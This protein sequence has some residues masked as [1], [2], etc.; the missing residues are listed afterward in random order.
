[1]ADLH[2]IKALN[3]FDIQD[4]EGLQLTQADVATL[5]NIGNEVF[6]LG[7]DAQG[8]ALGVAAST[9]G[10][11]SLFRM[12]VLQ[13]VGIGLVVGGVVTWGALRLLGKK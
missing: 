5:T 13:G 7:H 1:M 4:T 3:P 8:A 11:K 6:T 2:L 9:D 12:K 10:G